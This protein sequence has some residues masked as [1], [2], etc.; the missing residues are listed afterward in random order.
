M[1]SFTIDLNYIFLFLLI[2]YGFKDFFES[3][4]TKT[5][6]MKYFSSFSSKKNFVLEKL[7]SKHGHCV[8]RSERIFYDQLFWRCDNGVFWAFSRSAT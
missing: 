6:H 4:E 3:K 1:P 7:N 8:S 2:S 5:I